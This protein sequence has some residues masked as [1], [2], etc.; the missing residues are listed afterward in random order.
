MALLHEQ[1]YNSDDLSQINPSN[2]INSIFRQLNS[3]YNDVQTKVDFKIE[4]EIDEMS[5]DQA[6][7]CGLIVNELASNAF[8]HAFPNGEGTIHVRFVRDGSNY[9]LIVRDDG[10]GFPEDFDIETSRT[11]GITLIKRLSE[12]QLKGTLTIRDEEMTEITVEF[13]IEPSYET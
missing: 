13:P 11:L 2:F 12:D 3:T 1:L 10:V 9:R 8:E 4:V 6:I 7:P 5:I